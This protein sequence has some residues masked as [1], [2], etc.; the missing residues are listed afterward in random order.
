[1]LA[2]DRV[3]R[4]T[5]IEALNHPF[6]TESK[7]THEIT[8]ESKRLAKEAEKI[9]SKEITMFDKDPSYTIPISDVKKIVGADPE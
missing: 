2:F 5:A 1:M 3:D 9:K 4:F 7:A 6:F 8:D